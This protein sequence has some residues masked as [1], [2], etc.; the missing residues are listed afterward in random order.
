MQARPGQPVIYSPAYPRLGRTVRSGRLYVNGD[1]LE[2]SAFSR[3]RHEPSATGLVLDVV[4]QGCSRRV[5]LIQDSGH[6]RSELRRSS[7]ETLLICDAETEE[8]ICRITQAITDL[9][10]FGLCAGPAGFLAQLISATR[11]GVSAK[12]IVRA[13]SG[14]FLNGSFHPA[15]LKQTS[16]TAVAGSRVWILQESASGDEQIVREIVEDSDCPW[17]LVGT[18]SKR[19]G[20]PSVSERLARVASRIC[21][22]R[23]FESIVTFGGDTTFAI[24][25]A[26]AVDRI[27]PLD[28]LLPGIALSRIRVGGRDTLLVSKAGG[29]GE[30]ETVTDIRATLLG[31]Q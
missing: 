27:L 7:G 8:D 30:E 23:C 26:L 31:H 17:P 18:S 6:L 22:A 5:T 2:H 25:K 29:F 9:N 11:A 28:E 4:R 1:P 12:Q 3:D 10:A 21:L 14:L 16:A 19:L 15:S 24:L 13:R 20:G